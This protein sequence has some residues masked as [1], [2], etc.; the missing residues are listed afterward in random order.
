MKFII[1]CAVLIIAS[2]ADAAPSGNKQSQNDEIK[3]VTL[4]QPR[5]NAQVETQTLSFPSQDDFSH[6]EQSADNDF[7]NTKRT[8]HQNPFTDELLHSSIFQIPT[9]PGERSS[10]LSSTNM[11][12]ELQA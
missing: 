10:V 5:M 4:Q 8:S 6:Q 3:N 9:F 12:R 11:V 7:S 1:I 2:I